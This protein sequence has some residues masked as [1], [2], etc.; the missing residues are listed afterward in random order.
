[1]EIT[2]KFNFFSSSVLIV[3]LEGCLISE[4]LNVGAQEQ[5]VG[6]TYLNLQ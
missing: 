4:S 2:L 3:E 1:M 6:V 5:G